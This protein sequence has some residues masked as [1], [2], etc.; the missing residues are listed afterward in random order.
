MHFVSIPTSIFLNAKYFSPHKFKNVYPLPP[1]FLSLDGGSKQWF[2]GVQ[3]DISYIRKHTV[4][5]AI[6]VITRVQYFL[7][8]HLMIIDIM[9]VLD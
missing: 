2:S 1:Q 9:Y 4:Q 8:F 5:Y 7:L 6:N 3:C